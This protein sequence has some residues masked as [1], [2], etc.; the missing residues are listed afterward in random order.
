MLEDLVAGK[1][2]LQVHLQQGADEVLGLLLDPVPARS[3]HWSVAAT[4]DP[5]LLVG[6]IREGKAARQHLVE[7]D[8]QGPAVRLQ[9]VASDLVEL[10]P[11]HL[12]CHVGRGPRVG[13]QGVG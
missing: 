1:S 4:E 10:L 9:V 13:P 7:D 6:P 2:P 8:P 5:L 3:Y 12:G 11:G